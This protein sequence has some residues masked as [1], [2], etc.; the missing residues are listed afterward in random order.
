MKGKKVFIGLLVVMVITAGLV[1]ASCLD[2]DS[3]NYNPVG[4]WNA[5]DSYYGPLTLTVLENGTF[6]VRNNNGYTV[7]SGTYSISG[8]TVTFTVPGQGYGSAVFQDSN[9]VYV[10]FEP[11]NA[12]LVFTRN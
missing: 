3:D 4:T 7:Y 11:E 9:T 5:I 10:V 1:L 2:S 12:G 6:T 8:N